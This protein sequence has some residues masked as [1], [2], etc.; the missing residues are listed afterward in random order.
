MTTTEMSFS[1]Q[2]SAPQDP[3]GPQLQNVWVTGT[4][5]LIGR[6]LTA[7]LKAGGHT[8][9]PLVRSSPAQGQLLWNTASG[10]V[11]GSAPAAD[12]VVHLAGD[13]IADGR[14]TRAKMES[15]RSSR[16]QATRALCEHLATLETPPKVLVCA[17]AIG[18]YGDRGAE[19]LSEDARPGT[20]FL[21]DVCRE[22]EDACE[23]A[24]RVGI[25]VVNL[26][27]GV[28]L[29][30]GGGALAKMLTPF[31][32][33]AGGKLGSGDQYMSWISLDDVVSAIR[34][35]LENERLEGPVNATAPHPATNLAF[36][37][38][39]GRVLGRPTIAPMPAF[40]ARL[41]F[42]KMAD[43]LLLASINVL[44]RRLQSAGFTFAT[45]ELEPAL[46]HVLGRPQ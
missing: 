42:G 40:A 43:E 33:G 13:G 11:E 8:V 26:R 24:R 23:A 18:F 1:D 34:F 20:S 32:L 16:V 45:P 10:A 12:A 30:Q 7:R 31:K 29:A 25:R 19:E 35:A 9:V 22:W 5:G 2:Q 17:S 39:L 14:W 21:A 15:I 28:V 27:I 46:R 37:K 41:V 4:N 36:T 44:P 3:S 6:E 38:T